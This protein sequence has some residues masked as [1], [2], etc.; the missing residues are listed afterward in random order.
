MTLEGTHEE[1]DVEAA[2][3]ADDDD[4]PSRSTHMHQEEILLGDSQET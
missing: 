3:A 1:D 4:D 2:A